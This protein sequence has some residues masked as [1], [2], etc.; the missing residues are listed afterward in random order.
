MKISLVYQGENPCHLKTFLR[1]QGISRGL[2]AKI[3]HEGGAI[4]VDGTSGRKL[5]MIFP[6]AVVTLTMPPENVRKEPVIPSYVP[7]KILY[8]DRDFLIVDKP[9]HLATIPSTDKKHRYDSLVNRVVG[10]YEL[11]GIK[12][13]VV[14]VITRLDRDTTGIVLIA[15]HRYAH[16]LID[17][18]VHDHSIKKEYLALLSGKVDRRHF[19]VNLPIGREPGSMIKRTI[20]EDGKPSSSE[21]FLEK[22]LR[23]ASLY[24]VRLHSGRTHQIRVH[25]KAI[26]HPLVADTLYDGK[27][28]LPL[29]RQGLH[30]FHLVFYHPFLEKQ[31]EI[32]CNPPR[33]FEGYIKKNK[34]E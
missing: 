26:G 21:Y 29:Q 3:R 12:D 11:R 9:A 5:D 4:D 14:H 32:Y 33:D 25:S 27:N 6:N 18:Q 19:F 17:K 24:R 28:S 22:K 1:Q 34:K 20:T 7:L 13:T 2:L 15:K 23:D 30:C 8:E 10:Y 31:L 16:A